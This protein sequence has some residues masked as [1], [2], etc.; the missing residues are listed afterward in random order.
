MKKLMMMVAF[1]LLLPGCAESIEQPSLEDLGMIGTM[2]FDVADDN[3]IKVT[4]SMPLP[5]EK[6]EVQFSETVT[7]GHEAIKELSTVSDRDIS[8]AQLRTVLFSEEFA[9]TRGLKEM[10]HYLYRNPMIG[11]TVI[12]A[13]VKGSAQE[14]LEKKYKA[15]PNTSEYLNNLLHPRPRTAFHPFTTLH[16]FN[17]FKTSE[18]GDPLTPYLENDKDG[19]RVSKIALFD[20]D[21]LVTT[22][23]PEEAIIV[24][25]LHDNRKL[26]DLK[27]NVYGEKEDTIEKQ[28]LLN[29]VR[30]N[31]NI[32]SNGELEHP[33]FTINLKLKANVL[34]YH[35]PLSLD[36]QEGI[37]KL[38][39]LISEEVKIQ[40]Q[41]VLELLKKNKV[42]PVLL[43]EHMRIH[44]SK[45]EWTAEKWEEAIP[46]IEYEVSVTT[47]IKNSGTMK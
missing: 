6:R 24:S 22:I 18:V 19:L 35:G 37:N 46:K 31:V 2:G 42:D 25:A 30:S 4:V 28:V 33:F 41:D 34:E 43:G 36:G 1:L 17:F 45:N 23:T 20:Y 7:M 32:K 29:F 5:A 3:K 47:E 11:D 40:V 15:N 10:I 21:K 26:A 27:L 9:K 12:L 14:A 16:D 13:I 38:E 39:T 44:Y 8:G